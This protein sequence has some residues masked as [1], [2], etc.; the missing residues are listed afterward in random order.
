MNLRLKIILIGS[1]NSD[2]V[3]KASRYLTS[4]YLP[5]FDIT[6]LCYGDNVGGWSDYLLQQLCMMEDENI[7]FSLDDY[8]ISAPI[9]MDRFNAALAKMGGDVVLI[10][11][12]ES[13]PEEHEEYPVTTQYCIWNREYLMS[14][15]SR[16]N[17][18]WNFERTGSIEF[19]KDGHITLLET[20][21]HY[22]C[23]SSL[24]GRWEGI[25]LDGLNDEDRNYIIEHLIT[26]K[27]FVEK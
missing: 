22:H 15:L 18:P 1:P 11:L 21:I 7:I 25:R 12:C 13:T 26:E 4:K 5:E 8:L 17:S 14:I 16:T 24:S 23:N 3:A 10:K 2:P 19:R 6:Y 20:C 27:W 9:D